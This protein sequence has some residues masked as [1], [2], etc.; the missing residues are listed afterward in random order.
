MPYCPKCNMEFIDGI[1]TCSDCGGE[2][3]PSLEAY[4]AQERAKKKQTK[5]A[6]ISR[7]HEMGDIDASEIMD[8]LIH[9][10]DL[11][12]LESLENFETLLSRGREPE[13]ESGPAET[14]LFKEQK[15][16]RRP[17]SPGVYVSSR[18]R[19]EDMQSSSSAFLIVGG[20]TA[21]FAV[22]CWAGVIKLP[23]SE[24][25]RIFFQSVIT[26]SGLACLFVSVRTRSSIAALSEQAN[27][28]EQRTKE[29]IEWFTASWTGDVLD[30]LLK[31]ESPDLTGEELELKRFE[32][33]QDYLVTGRDLPE[34]AYVDFLAEEIYQE[35]Y[36]G[37]RTQI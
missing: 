4:E 31:T 16:Q 1:T 18:Q 2:L 11:T 21:V 17:A 5:E 34:Q 14:A 23:M 33:I 8:N 22:L 29:L 24:G 6:A 12:D 10:D 32:L 36:E 3:T 37:E 15:T 7:Y 9:F 13:G 20:A 19:C 35:L 25:S 30:E 26:L 27:A 28:E